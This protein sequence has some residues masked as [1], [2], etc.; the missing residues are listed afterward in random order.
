[1]PKNYTAISWPS[2]VQN[3]SLLETSAITLS[4]APGPSSPLRHLLSLTAV[5]NLTALMHLYPL[6]DHPEP[7][8]TSDLR[9]WTRAVQEKNALPALKVLALPIVADD[10]RDST[11]LRHLSSL[12]AL[13]VVAIA[14]SFLARPARQPRPGGDEPQ[15]SND[16]ADW[17]PLDRPRNTAFSDILYGRSSHSR[18]SLAQR[19]ELLCASASADSVAEGEKGKGPVIDLSLTCYGEGALYRDNAGDV[20]WF[21]RRRP[22]RERGGKRML[23]PTPS[24]EEEEEDKGAKKRKVKK[25]RKQDLGA[26]L[27]SFG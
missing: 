18:L 3:L 15:R 13:H 24:R 27:G 22:A 10:V 19:A 7:L 20:E 14:K 11:V 8:T 23:G 1:M 16:D 4:C 12:P 21:V 26:L 6:Q 2:I 25:A 9:V 5:P 17:E